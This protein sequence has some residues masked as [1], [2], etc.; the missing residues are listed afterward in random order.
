MERQQ[1][2]KLIKDLNNAS[3]AYYN[4]NEIMSNLEWD[5]KFDELKS[6]E[7]KTG[8]YFSDSP[9]KNV[10]FVPKVGTKVTHEYPARSLDKTK[11]AS[12]LAEK[13]SKEPGVLIMWKLDGGTL[14][15]TYEAGKLKVCATRGNGEVGQDITANA[16]KIIGIPKEIS[17]SGKLVVRGEAL[18]SYEDFYNI[19]AKLPENEQYANPRNLA[20]AT[21]SMLDPKVVESRKI[22]FKVFGIVYSE[23]EISNFNDRM[24]W[25]KELGFD[26]VEWELVTPDKIPWAITSISAKIPEYPYPVDGLVLASNDIGRT[27]KLP[28]TGHHPNVLAGFAFKWADTEAKTVLREIEWSPSRTGLLNPVAIFDPVE[29]EGTTVTRASLHNVSY[30]M[31]KHLHIQDEIT[32]YKANMII[33]QIKDNLSE[34]ERDPNRKEEFDFSVNCPVCGNLA[35]LFMVNDVYT[36]RCNNPL[37]DAKKIGSFVHFCSRD[38]MDIEGMSEATITKFVE[39]GFLHKL[40]DFYHLDRFKEEIIEM[41]G[42]GEKSYKNLSSAIEKSKSKDIVSFLT[43]IGIA[44]IGKGQAKQISLH[45]DGRAKSVLESIFGEEKYDFSVIGGI[46][47]VINNSIYQYAEN[48]KRTNGGILGNL[49]SELSLSDIEVPK[50]MD[51]PIAGK[52]FV[53]TGNVNHFANRNELKAE[54]ESLGGKV[55]GSVTQKTDYLINNDST[56]TSGK[57]KKAKELNI[58]VITE[59][60]YIEMVGK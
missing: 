60:E 37:C 25:L 7:E 22:H 23:K 2:E 55:T 50:S 14:Q 26:T 20:N 16:E 3:N 32:V 39:K 5:E 47:E 57:N 18:M 52:T 58:P 49:L 9:T 48:Y 42:F 31:E 59:D 53:I 41:E 54:I 15:L 56:S 28:G 38:C 44:N 12:V 4:G 40:E 51:S 24:E 29:L 6:L 1:I 13:M 30:I 35:E 21:V 11:D 45:F 36:M 8:I 10:G 19:N 43:A 17:Y 46:G 27:E 34:Q 33:P